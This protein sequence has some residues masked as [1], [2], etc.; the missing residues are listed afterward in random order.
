MRM[1]L[2]AEPLSVRI[3][4][5]ATRHWLREHGHTLAEHAAA[6]VV[7]ELVTNS[8]VHACAPIA[9]HLWDRSNEVRLGVSDGSTAVACNEPGEP[10]ATSGR[11]MHLIE[12]ACSR[13]GSEVDGV[14]KLTWADIPATA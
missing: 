14:G 13:W 6:I 12:S 7:S 9:L 8:I 2:E 3:A 4:R 11:G 1:P 10:G 5:D